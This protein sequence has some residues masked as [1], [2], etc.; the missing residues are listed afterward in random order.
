M[1][2]SYD[3][4]LLREDLFRIWKNLQQPT[5]TKFWD[6]FKSSHEY[7]I[8][9][10]PNKTTV[11]NYIKGFAN[12][13]VNFF[14]GR[15]RPKKTFAITADNG[16]FSK[17]MVDLMETKDFCPLRPYL[18]VMMDV[19]TRYLCYAFLKSKNVR[20]VETAFM[21]CFKE[22]G[23]VNGFVP[24]HFIIQGDE[25]S[26]WNNSKL[27]DEF[28]K[29]NGIEP[30]FSN[31]DIRIAS[32]SERVIRTIRKQLTKEVWS[33][34]PASLIGKFEDF[35][36]DFAHLYND[37]YMNR[38]IRRTPQQLIQMNPKQEQREYSDRMKRGKIRGQFGYASGGFRSKFQIGDRVHWEIFNG[39]KKSTIK[40]KGGRRFSTATAPIE[41]IN[42][43]GK[44]VVEG[45]P[46]SS[47][48][49]DELLPDRNLYQPVALPPHAHSDDFDNDEEYLT[50][51]QRKRKSQLKRRNNI[52]SIDFN[53]QLSNKRQR[54]PSSN[55]NY[56]DQ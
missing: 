4:S 2:S 46:S 26:S 11:T 52:E 37:K 44:Y 32:L 36:K 39:N 6:V 43:W 42:K 47:F 16:P 18:M 21:T 50:Q 25:E 45:L 56:D 17:L 14:E 48:S 41:E 3:S 30:H 35:I 53:N 29:K 34:T 28:Y 20:D 38:T 24:D 1:S 9:G 49:A 5:P 27:M 10:L 8:F 12:P 23:D 51:P 13:E 7:T 15:A 19:R 55:A 22:I 31:M 40:S 54:K 33:G